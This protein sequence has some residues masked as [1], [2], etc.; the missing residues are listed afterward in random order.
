MTRA[1]YRLPP[2]PE[3]FQIYEER[4]EVAGLAHRKADAAQFARG[5]Q[6]ALEWEP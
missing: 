3:G 6:K 2:I 5:K 4:L 1:D